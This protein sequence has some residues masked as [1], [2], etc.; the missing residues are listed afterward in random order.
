MPNIEVLAYSPYD[1]TEF[2]DYLINGKRDANGNVALD[3][4]DRQI[5][6]IISWL[7]GRQIPQ[8]R[9]FSSRVEDHIKVFAAMIEPTEE[10][11]VPWTDRVPGLCRMVR[12]DGKIGNF[13][14]NSPDLNTAENPLG[15]VIPRPDLDEVYRAR[16][17]EINSV[18]FGNLT[19]SAEALR[20]ALQGKKGTNL[21]DMLREISE[22]DRPVMESFLTRGATSQR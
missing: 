15:L 19:F 9:F 10:E 20:G 7:H 3:D 12:M 13:T 4:D 6:G 2:N 17:D 22:A 16:K 8:A 5:T 11:D 18:N 21:R 1:W 14:M